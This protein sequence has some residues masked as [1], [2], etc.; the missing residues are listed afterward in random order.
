MEILLAGKP[1]FVGTLTEPDRTTWECHAQGLAFQ[2]KLA[3]DGSG[4]ATRDL[5]TAIAEAAA[6][7]WPVGNPD[8]IAGTVA[9]DSGDPQ[10]LGDLFD[11]Y[12][13]QTGKRW[14]VDAR[15]ILFLTADPTAPM[16]ITTP[17]AVAFGAT[18]EGM[19]KAIAARFLEGGVLDTVFRGDPTGDE[20][21][22]DLTKRGNITTAQATSIA[23]Q[24]LATRKAGSGWVNGV[25]LTRDQIN[26]VGGSRAP[27]AD[28][29]GGQMLR[30]YGLPQ[31]AANSGRMYLD[32]VIGKTRYTADEDTIYLEP[33]NKAPR[34]A[35]EVWAAG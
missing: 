29:R 9:G 23:D 35:R 32:V 17:G 13:E 25:T 27:L 22:V 1:M 24:I 15:Q 2:K 33:V 14:G 30:V 3:L 31:L 16:W 7:G 26:T 4:A 34:T 28:I 8:G 20:E 6:R 12:A 19:A 21:P 10:T 18:N 11:Q 5:S